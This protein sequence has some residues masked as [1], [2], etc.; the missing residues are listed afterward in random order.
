MQPCSFHGSAWSFIVGASSYCE[1][2]ALGV[3]ANPPVTKVR[4]A[5][6]AK[7]GEALTNM[8]MGKG[9]I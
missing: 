5:V 8:V 6:E 4:D 7:K 9:S 3:G 2:Q 1:A